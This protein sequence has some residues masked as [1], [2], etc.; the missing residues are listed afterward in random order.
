MDLLYVLM[1][2][3]MVLS[4]I[5]SGKVQRTFNKHANEPVASGCRAAEAVDL[6]LRRRDA[7][8]TVGTVSGSL[9]DHY[10]PGADTVRLSDCVYPSNSVSAVAVAAHECGH[11][12][13]Y[14]EGYSLIRIRSKILPVANFGSK[15][16]PFLILGGL[17]LGFSSLAMLGVWLYGIMLLFQLLTLPVELNASSR[18]LAMLQ[19]DGI[20]SYDQ[21]PAAKEML[22]A[23]A[24]TYVWAALSALV[25]FLRLFLIASRSRR[26]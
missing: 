15:V 16:S 24:M 26:R 3:I 1:L 23:A 21:V 9:T 20:I 25:S 6:M 17:I 2:V 13:Q 14:R 8:I 4:L 18:A 10:D 5:A 7:G 11:V 19:E 22:R 12:M